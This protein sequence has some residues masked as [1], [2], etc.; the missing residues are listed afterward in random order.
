MTGEVLH[1]PA[2]LMERQRSVEALYTAKDVL[3]AALQQ[4][5]ERYGLLFAGR[6][7]E[8][9]DTHGRAYPSQS[10]AD[11]AFCTM[12]ASVKGTRE[13]LDTLMH[14]S[15]LDRQK[16]SRE[17]YR[18]NTLTKAIE[19]TSTPGRRENKTPQIEKAR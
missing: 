9:R 14:L 13:L 17:D 11:L 10:E 15:G 3:I 6:W 8:A 4:Y 18:K 5:G 2:P 7:E 12:G 1:T 19:G 16:W